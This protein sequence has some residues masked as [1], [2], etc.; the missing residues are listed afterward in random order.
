MFGI[1]KHHLVP[2]VGLVRHIRKTLHYM[3]VFEERQMLKHLPGGVLLSLYNSF[4]IV[5]PAFA[6][7]SI[8]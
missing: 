1:E 8:V 2:L 7:I 4:I 6:F 3:E 5:G